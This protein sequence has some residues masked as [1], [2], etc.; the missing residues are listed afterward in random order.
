MRLSEVA[1]Y[2]WIATAYVEFFRGLPVLI[3]LPR[4]FRTMIPPLTNE[5]IMLIKDA[6]LVFAIGLALSDFELTTFGKSMAN[7]HANI[8]P[9]VVAGLG[10][11][12]VTLPLRLE[13]RRRPI[14]D[15]VTMNVLAGPGI[16]C[17]TRVSPVLPCSWARD[18]QAGPGGYG[19]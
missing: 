18:R 16:V 9:V 7:N 12:V 1:P 17:L 8:T 10:C 4:A 2:R 19:Q 15:S 14:R 11:L 5:L 3:V 6:S 13:V